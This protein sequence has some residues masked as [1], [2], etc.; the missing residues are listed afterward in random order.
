MY[1]N[2]KWN[3]IINEYRKYIT[4]FTATTFATN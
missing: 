3:S 2:G 1:N 4:T